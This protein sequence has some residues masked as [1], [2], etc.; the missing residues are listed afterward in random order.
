MSCP[1]NEHERSENESPPSRNQCWLCQKELLRLILYCLTNKKKKQY[2]VV[3]EYCHPSLNLLKQLCYDQN[4]Q[5][6]REL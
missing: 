3:E 2:L 6:A 5:I 1:I 4:R